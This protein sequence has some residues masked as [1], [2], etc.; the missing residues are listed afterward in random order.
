MVRPAQFAIVG[1]LAAPVYAPQIAS[2]IGLAMLVPVLPLYLTQGGLDF[3]EAS[4]VLAAAGV[5][6]ALGSLPAGGLV[7]RIGERHLVTLSLVVIAVAAMIVGT[8]TAVLALIAL[9]LAMGAGAAA[10]RLANQTTVTRSV[11]G[12]ERG[13]AMS[14]MGGSMR[15]AYLVGPL[16]GGVLVDAVGFGPTFVVVGAIAASGLIPPLLHAAPVA[17]NTSAVAPSGPAGL[18]AALVRHRR[19]LLRS[20]VGPALVMSVRSGRLVVVPLIGDELGLS[21]TAVGALVAVGTGADLLLFPIA[22]LVMD[23]F[24]R[25]AAMVPAFGLL[26]VGLLVLSIAHNTTMVIIAGVIMGV[27]NGMS[28]GTMLTLASDLAPPGDTGPFLAAMAAMQDGGRI[29]GPLL[30]GWFADAAGLGTSA[31]VLAI[32][33]FVG[34][35]WIVGV[36]GETA[37]RSVPVSVLRGERPPR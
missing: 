23:R 33:M 25:L 11:V 27:G 19:L 15:L 9:Q 1:R 37:P 2:G 6:G 26:G 21:P 32:A 8:T 31:F 3:T 35:G 29:L 30:V 22:G 20:G 13:R 16:V 7:A 24:G 28:A 34:I 36:I 4:I 14:L 12:S 18:R 5:G 10:L 17:S